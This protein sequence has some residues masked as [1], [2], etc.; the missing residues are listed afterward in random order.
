LSLNR[1][2]GQERDLHVQ[3]QGLGLFSFQG[4]GHCIIKDISRTFADW[5]NFIY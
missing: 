5:E 4:Q 3:G 1:I 2:Q